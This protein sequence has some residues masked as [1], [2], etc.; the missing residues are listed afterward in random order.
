MYLALLIHRKKSGKA[1][2]VS[3]GSWRWCHNEN[4]VKFENGEIM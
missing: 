4:N 3:V 2:K 1:K